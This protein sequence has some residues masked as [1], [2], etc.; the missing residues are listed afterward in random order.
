[1]GRKMAEVC[2]QPE[3]IGVLGA[4]RPSGGLGAKLPAAG[5]KG[6]GWRSLQS[7]AIFAI[8]Q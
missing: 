5:G 6:S 4:K 3:A 8:V 2:C 1:M 7:W